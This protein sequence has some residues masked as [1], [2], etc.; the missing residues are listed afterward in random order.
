[1]L[2]FRAGFLHFS[3]IPYKQHFKVKIVS[4]KCTEPVNNVKYTDR[5]KWKKSVVSSQFVSLMYQ[6]KHAT[7]SFFFN[8]A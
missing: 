5:W 4:M 3:P 1:M 8:A 2:I 7:K 6:Q